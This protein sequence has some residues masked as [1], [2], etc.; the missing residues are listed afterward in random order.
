FLVLL[1]ADIMEEMGISVRH[2][3][4]K[5]APVLQVLVIIAALVCLVYFGAY[6]QG[7]TN[8]QFLYGRV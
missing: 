1:F 4:E 2:F 7:Y 5:R 8:A 3:L 6:R